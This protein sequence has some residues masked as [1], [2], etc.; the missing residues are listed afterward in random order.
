MEDRVGE[1]CRAHGV[2]KTVIQN[3]LK[4]PE[5]KY[6]LSHLGIDGK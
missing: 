5:G 1:T 2:N 6:R 4:E 3:L